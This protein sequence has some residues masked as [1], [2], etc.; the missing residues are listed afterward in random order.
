ML[1]IGKLSADQASYY[2][3][4][5][6]V[7]V[8]AVST[9]SP[10]R[11]VLRGR[12]RTCS[13]VTTAASGRPAI[14]PP[15]QLRLVA[16]ARG[17]QRHL[18]RPPARPRSRPHAEHVRPHDRRARRGAADHRRRGH[19]RREACPAKRPSVTDRVTR[20]VTP[21]VPA[22]AVAPRAWRLSSGQPVPGNASST[23][24]LSMPRLRSHSAMRPSRS[25][26]ARSS[27]ASTRA[28]PRSPSSRSSSR[29]VIGGPG[30]TG[31][32]PRLG[33]SPTV[34]GAG[35]R[36]PPGG[37]WLLA[38]GSVTARPY[39]TRREWLMY[40]SGTRDAPR[41]KA[42]KRVLGSPPEAPRAGFEPAAYSLGGS[43]SIRLS[44]RG[45]QRQ[46]TAAGRGN[47]RVT[48]TPAG[49][50]VRAGRRG[51]LVGFSAS[52]GELSAERA[53]R[54][55]RSEEGYIL[56]TARTEPEGVR[57]S[58]GTSELLHS[59]GSGVDVA[60][61]G[62][63]AR[64]RRALAAPALLAAAPARQGRDGRAR[65]HRP[66]DPRRDL[67]AADRQARRRARPEHA[68]DRRAGR[69]RPALRARAASTSS[70][71]TRSAATCSRARSTA[72]A[73][74]SRSRSSPP[75]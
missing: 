53:R 56:G 10:S 70:A 27:R 36:G 21:L 54:A 41:S 45:R 73:S 14:R 62:R 75:R 16:P 19:R 25:R 31:S 38:R 9:T 60:S 42:E 48:C 72:R 17:A 34:G 30:S 35:G 51:D 68:V 23:A 67:R 43:R 57:M 49:T 18:R 47:T 29:T 74:R 39:G 4:Q 37:R 65:L 59:E 24:S 26:T 2:L 15:P 22:A 40:P 13:R 20:R 7:R 52:K 69:L 61:H 3:D 1:S 11:S 32:G 44:Y 63:A 8:D 71:S 58:T 12:A 50:C 28:F 55:A 33:G 66:A 46:D 5:A 64:D 6:E